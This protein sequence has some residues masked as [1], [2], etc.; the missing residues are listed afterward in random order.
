MSDEIKWVEVIKKVT[1][2]EEKGQSAS[3]KDVNKTVTTTRTW[4]VNPAFPDVIK[5]LASLPEN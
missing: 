4:S 2:E 1:V 3:G 5:M